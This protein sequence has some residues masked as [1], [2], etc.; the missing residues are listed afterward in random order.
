MNRIKNSSYPLISIQILNWNRAHETLRAIESAINQTYPNKEI[1]IVDNGSSDNSVELINLNYP[2]LKV[3]RLDKNYGCPGGRNKGVD[4]C[5]GEYIFYLDN[6]GVLHQ[7]ALSNAYSTICEAGDIAVVTGK[8]VEFE[9]TNEIDTT[10]KILH[11]KSYLTF[12]FQGGVCLHRKAIYSKV[13]FYPEHFIY[14]SEEL[15]LS[16]Q[17]IENDLKIV[18]NDSVI[19]W[20]KASDKARDKEKETMLS[21]YNKLY[22]AA[23]LYP[24]KFAFIFA[25]AYPFRYVIHAYNEN[26]WYQF[27][28]SFPSKYLGTLFLAISNRN[29]PISKRT[30]LKVNNSI[31]Q[32]SV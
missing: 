21:Y 27:I 14:G 29:R 19:L 20:H 18:K 17:I 7:D 12:N 13:G 23:N 22:T 10:Y 32:K 1:I 9:N 2:E 3:I 4:F 26:L 5:N 6:D 16:Y 15:F 31:K 25:I 11:L 30:Y 8:V 28:K 24:A